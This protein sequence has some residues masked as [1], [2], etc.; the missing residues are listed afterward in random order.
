MA[1]P[2][3]LFVYN[4]PEHTK[5]TIEALKRNRGAEEAELFIF[6]DGAIDDTE[7]G[8]V[9]AVREYLADLKSLNVF[10]NV[11]IVTQEKNRGLEQSIICGVTKI[12]NQYGE[13]IVLEDDIITAPDFLLFMNDALDAYRE[14]SKV[15]SISSYSVCN[16]KTE[17]CREDVLWT[18]RGECWGWASWADRWNKV[19]WDV[20]DYAEFVQNRK[21]QKSF[22]RAGRDM[23]L[24]LEKQQKGELNSWAI[25]WC[26]QQFK[27]DMI[28]IFP[29]YQKS[30]NDGLDGTGT[31]CGQEICDEVKFLVEDNWNFEYSLDN[32]VLLKKF[33]K[34]YALSFWRQKIG[35]IWYLLTEYEYCLAYK[36]VGESCNI[37]K[38]NYREWYADPI[39]FSWEGEDYVFVEV[40]RK[41]KEKGSIGICKLNKDGKLSRPKLII[42]ESFHLSFPSITVINGIVYMVP[43]CSEVEQIRIYRMQKDIYH[44]KLYKA[45][46]N[47]GKLVDSILYRNKD[48]KVFLLSCELNKNNEYQTRIKQYEMINFANPDTMELK[49]N[50]KHEEYSYYDRNGGNFLNDGE[51]IYRVVQQSTAKVY[52]KAVIINKIV[53]LDEEDLKEVFCKKI[54]PH[55]EKIELMPFVYRKWGIHTYGKTNKIE[56]I[57]LL[58]QRFSFAG[59]WYK[60]WRR[61]KR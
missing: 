55:T 53:K 37:L 16:K 40:Y 45:F 3:A 1:A 35:K 60:I 38:P 50:W 30:Y 61:M 49:L 15:W 13:I 42:E 24:L 43:E 4:R 12:I 58:V 22:N 26:Y 44:W 56:I 52:G 31:N 25:R 29:K 57:D 46:E 39:P 17:R 51:N 5:R 36:S 47:V 10:K 41:F 48:G 20:K 59:L 2:I 54:T 6:S 33:Q 19:D 7:K 32:Q 8:N 34:K 23:T 11:E 28:T 14:D 21:M 18:Y 9:E 27:E